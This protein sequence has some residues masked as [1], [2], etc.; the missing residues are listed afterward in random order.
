MSSAVAD[1]AKKINDL[2][3]VLELSCTS[4]AD[5]DKSRQARR[6]MLKASRDLSFALWNERQ[7]VED[8]LY[9]VS[10]TAQVLKGSADISPARLSMSC[11]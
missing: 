6:D 5:S 9:S 8:Y 2:S 11:C 4:D 1:L 3:H 10:G 7:I